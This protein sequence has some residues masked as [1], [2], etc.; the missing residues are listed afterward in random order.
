MLYFSRLTIHLAGDD[1]FTE[2]RGA[3][4]VMVVDL[5]FHE[6]TEA[7]EHCASLSARLAILNDLEGVREFLEAHDTRMLFTHRELGNLL[8]KDI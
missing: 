6:R 3:G 2:I 7:V 5:E 4:F 1:G 8:I